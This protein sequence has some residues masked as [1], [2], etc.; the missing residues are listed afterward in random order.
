MDELVTQYLTPA[1]LLAL[2]GMIGTA[3]AG[4]KRGQKEQEGREE[5]LREHL[6]NRLLE[7]T[8]KLEDRLREQDAHI[9]AQDA[10]I[11]VWRAKFFELQLTHEGMLVRMETMKGELEELRA[12]KHAFDLTGEPP[13]QRAG[14]RRTDPIVEPPPVN[15]MG[16]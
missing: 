14:R 13:P 5:K 16:E 12:W 9:K 10:E 2:L 1:T 3:Y 11:T 7:Y 4:W 15:E 6:D 8:R